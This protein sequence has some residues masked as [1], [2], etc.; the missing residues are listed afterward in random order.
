MEICT[1]Q[2][3]DSSAL[4]NNTFLVENQPSMTTNELNQGLNCDIDPEFGLIEKRAVLDKKLKAT[5][6]SI[7]KKYSKDFEGIGD[8]IDIATGEIV[9]NNGHLLR[10]QIKRKDDVWNSNRNQKIR[11][12]GKASGGLI[13]SQRTKGI[14]CNEDDVEQDLRGNLVINEEK[15]VE[16]F[17]GCNEDDL[18]LRGI[19]RANQFLKLSSKDIPRSKLET[20]RRD[21]AMC[22]LSFQTEDLSRVNT[23]TREDSPCT[24]PQYRNKI[25]DFT[26]HEDDIEPAWRLPKLPLSQKDVCKKSIENLRSETLLTVHPNISINSKFV[27]YWGFEKQARR[28][29]LESHQYSYF[30]NFNPGYA[31]ENIEEKKMIYTKNS[32]DSLLYN[33]NTKIFNEKSSTNPASFTFTDSKDSKASIIK[34]FSEPCEQ[35]ER[36]QNIEFT[37]ITK[38]GIPLISEVGNCSQKLPKLK[39]ASLSNDNGLISN[40]SERSSKSPSMTA[41]VFRDTLK[42]NVPLDESNTH[43]IHF[44]SIISSSTIKKNHENKKS[45]ETV[46]KSER[47][48]CRILNDQKEANLKSL[49]L[50]SKNPST[51]VDIDEIKNPRSSNHSEH[52][53]NDRLLEKS[54]KVPNQTYDQPPKSIEV[55]LQNNDKFSNIEPIPQK[56][57]NI[58]PPTHLQTKNQCLK[59]STPIKTNVYTNSHISK[60]RSLM[61]I[62]PTRNLNPEAK[63]ISFK[64]LRQRALKNS[65]NWSPK[66]ED[67]DELS[68]DQ[69][70]Q[71]PQFIF[72]FCDKN[73]VLQQSPRVFSTIK[74]KNK[75][76]FARFEEDERDELSID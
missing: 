59:I 55:N 27:E 45:I 34:Q 14:S 67:V 49:R 53:F 46:N 35:E 7:F 47:S 50:S 62:T 30:S 71:N 36:Q 58:M 76:S 52:G 24:D 8:E 70:S 4:I 72:K 1:K 56:G 64:S 68:L 31:S 2:R 12:E 5:F 61:P 13:I 18:I 9:V 44:S 22:P 43:K 40:I 75:R 29:R 23:L 26:D 54:T 37:S 39:F 11:I 33:W 20:F 25:I 63:N 17:S 28:F 3:R 57:I 38:N 65:L 74:N 69:P 15:I 10:M 41:S 51:S 21:F 48:Y 6:E 42:H 73:Q 32:Q 66:S 16:P 60:P 19:V